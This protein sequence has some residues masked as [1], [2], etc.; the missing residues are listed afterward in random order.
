MKKNKFNMSAGTVTLDL[1]TLE[2]TLGHS[3]RVAGQ[4]VYRN[5]SEIQSLLEAACFAKNDGDEQTRYSRL[6]N[7]NTH[8]Q[9][10][11]QAAYEY[12]DV[13]EAYFHVIEAVR[14]EEVNISK[15]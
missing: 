15:E 5:Y 2:S 6:C 1:K 7:A 11:V 14:R 13:I 8:R 4:E 9:W 10:L 12:A 3:V